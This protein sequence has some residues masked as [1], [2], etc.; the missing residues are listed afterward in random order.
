MWYLVVLF[1]AG[2]IEGA[3]LVVCWLG[4]MEVF[5]RGGVFYVFVTI[6]NRC[7]VVQ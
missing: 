3:Y 7:L 2:I 6:C 5:S 4:I 1:Q